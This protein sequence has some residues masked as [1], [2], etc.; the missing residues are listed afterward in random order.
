MALDYKVIASRIMRA[1]KCSR[2]DAWTAIATVYARDKMDTTRSEGEQA[3]WLVKAAYYAVLQERIN[4]YND[5]CRF[6]DT[7]IPSD[8]DA[9]DLW[10]T[11]AAPPDPDE[12]A[13]ELRRD[14]L[15]A[16]A[17]QYRVSLAIVLHNIMASRFRC[18]LTVEAIRQILR[19][20]GITKSATD[21]AT[22]VYTYLK[23]FSY[24][25]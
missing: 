7:A 17:R 11:I 5:E 23:T 4:R 9:L 1:A 24:K 19:R 14:M 16:C 25:D 6:V 21:Q 12:L 8:E 20:A 13:S 10:D 2:D 22:N 3:N 15:R 18:E